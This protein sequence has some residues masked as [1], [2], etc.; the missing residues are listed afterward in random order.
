[1]PTDTD[2]DPCGG[3]A[4][5]PVI[6]Q[7]PQGHFTLMDLLTIL[8]TAERGRRLLAGVLPPNHGRP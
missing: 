1:M 3:T 2:T 7:V 5:D 6:A 8:G 4:A